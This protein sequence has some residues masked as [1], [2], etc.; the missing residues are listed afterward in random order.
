VT[1]ANAYFAMNAVFW[2][3]AARGVTL[4][5]SNVTAVAD[6]AGTTSVASTWAASASNPTFN[7]SSAKF[8]GRPSFSFNGGDQFLDAGNCTPFGTSGSGSGSI[9]S[10]AECST[11]GSNP[12]ATIVGLSYNTFYFQ[13]GLDPGGTG[14]IGWY[15]STSAKSGFTNAT[16]K[17]NTAHGYVTVHD[18]SLGSGNT[19]INLDGTVQTAKGNDTS[20]FTTTTDHLSV[21]RQVDTTGLGSFG[22]SWSGEISEVF[23][24]ADAFSGPEQA[25]LMAKSTVGSFANLNGVGA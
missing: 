15:T 13:L 6:Q 10:S 20:G 12:N 7:A 4:S 8:N 24:E 5:G 25:F 3:D 19:Y 11:A 21:G 17:D 1:L 18:N 23:G 22:V 16:V 2:L 14:E 9:C